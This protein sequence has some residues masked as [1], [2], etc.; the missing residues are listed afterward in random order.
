MNK[1]LIKYVLLVLGMVLSLSSCSFAETKTK[2]NTIMSD[3]I[4]RKEIYFAE[5][6]RVSYNPKAVKV[7]LLI[8]LFLK[9]IDP[10]SLNRQGGDIGTQYRTGIYYVNDEDIPF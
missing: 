3:N 9:T 2:N 7:D 4:E 5:T 6:V 8:E 10:T 1:H